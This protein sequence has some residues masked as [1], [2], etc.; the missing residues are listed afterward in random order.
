MRNRI[1]RLK[2][3]T[4]AG[5]DVEGAPNARVGG[6][7]ADSRILH[8]ALEA[9]ELDLSTLDPAG[10]AYKL[11]ESAER[12]GGARLFLEKARDAYLKPGELSEQIVQRYMQAF[13]LLVFGAAAASLLSRV[14]TTAMGGSEAVPREV[15]GGLV[16]AAV[17][18]AATGAL[19]QG[20]SVAAKNNKR[21]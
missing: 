9:D 4:G 5:G 15:V 1:D 14:A 19:T 12:W 7:E 11:L 18:L 20:I 13:H 10:L 17:V 16:A 8:A 21:A 2:N 6:L 3:K